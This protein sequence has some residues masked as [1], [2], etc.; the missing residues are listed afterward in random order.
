MHPAG[1]IDRALLEIEEF[2]NERSSQPDPRSKMK[3]DPAVG[4]GK[5]E[6]RAIVWPKWH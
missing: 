1:C 2:D 6:N 4:S 5:T 3:Q